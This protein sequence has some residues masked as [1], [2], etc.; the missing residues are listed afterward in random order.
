[1]MMVIKMTMTMIFKLSFPAF[2]PLFI[3]DDDDDDD[4]GRGRGSLYCRYRHD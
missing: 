4:D 3:T 2:V 1:M